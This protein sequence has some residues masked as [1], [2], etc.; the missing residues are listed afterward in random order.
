MGI[1]L[2]FRRPWWGPP[3]K[4]AIPRLLRTCPPL[5][6]SVRR[7]SGFLALTAAIALAAFLS[8]PWFTDR[9]LRAAAGAAAAV[10]DGDSLRAGDIDIRLIGI[11]APELRQSCRESDGREWPCGRAAKARLAALVARGEIACAAQGYDRYRRMLAVCS[12]GDVADLGEA[13][14]REGYAV[15]YGG[16]TSRYTAAEAEA[17]ADGRGLW[18]G[19][20]ERP[21]D[22][23][24][25]HRRRQTVGSSGR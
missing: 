24:A 8:G 13:L 10:I 22:W 11:D 18:R 14:V 17:R 16:V 15:H 5:P 4:L 1:A 2:P 19:S 20:F 7:H 21:E 12:A 9:P 3:R 6:A 25:G 23:R